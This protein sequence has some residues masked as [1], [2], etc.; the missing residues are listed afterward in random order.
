M[1]NG[2]GYTTI[3][4]TGQVNGTFTIPSVP[5]GTVLIR[6]DNLYFE[7]ATRQANFVNFSLGRPN[8]VT[9]TVNPTT[10]IVAVT[11]LQPWVAGQDQLIWVSP[12]VGNRF[13]NFPVSPA[14]T[15]GATTATAG[16]NF[17][18][19]KL[20][21]QAEGDDTWLLQYRIVADGGFLGGT[22]V[23]AAQLAPFTQLN[24]QS[25]NLNAAM[26]APPNVPS[27]TQSFVWNLNA[28]AALQT[29]L[30]PGTNPRGLLALSPVPSVTPNTSTVVD[31]WAVQLPASQLPPSSFT[32][33]TPFPS[34][35]S[36]VGR[37]FFTIDTPRQVAGTTGPLAM[38]S[39]FGHYDTMAALT[40]SPITPRLGPV[41]NLTLNGTPFTTERSSVGTTVTL[42]WTAPSTGTV[43]TYY[44]SVSRLTTASTAATTKAETFELSTANTSIVLPADRLIANQPYVI[45]VSAYSANFNAR[46]DYSTRSTPLALSFVNSP[47]FRP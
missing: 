25:T 1:P 36:I 5:A 41:T 35:W 22:T 32:L 20:V 12:N 40:S 10:T 18:G 45:E 43:T 7:T 24:G 47:I 33:V 28:F 6:A 27:V 4:G 31:S 30:P 44:V 38:T 42:G 16:A 19:A 9:A 29:S 21:S 8:A 2:S 26:L 23:A 11:G 37:A 13:G 17:N 15:A 14:P 46:V 34:G 39:G 3:T